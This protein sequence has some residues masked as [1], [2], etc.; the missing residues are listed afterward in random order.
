MF[1]LNLIKINEDKVLISD[2]IKLCDQDCYRAAY[3]IAW[4]ACV[5]AL[6]RRFFEAGKKVNN[7]NKCVGEIKQKED[8]HKSI[9]KFIIGKAKEFDFISDTEKKIRVFL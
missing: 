7:I 2:A 3:I 5:E 6:K 8:Q 1:D 9:D 4:L